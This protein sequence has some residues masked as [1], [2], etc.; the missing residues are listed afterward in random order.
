ME[1]LAFPGGAKHFHPPGKLGCNS[2][3]SPGVILGRERP[4]M[5]IPS[6][7]KELLLIPGCYLLISTLTANRKISTATAPIINNNKS[8]G[9]LFPWCWLKWW[10][11]ILKKQRSLRKECLSGYLSGP[12]QW[13]TRI[14]LCLCNLQEC[15]APAAPGQ[16]AHVLAALK[17][18]TQDPVP[19]GCD[20]SDSIN[21]WDNHSLGRGSS[22]V[23]NG[24]IPLQEFCIPFLCELS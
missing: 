23:Q 11:L 10:G 3:L 21:L 17:A 19:G 7:I 24:F 8:I 2:L 18:M 12:E 22:L 16:G 14:H 9:S 13:D 15:P 6:I 5:E 4:R 20:T 1:P